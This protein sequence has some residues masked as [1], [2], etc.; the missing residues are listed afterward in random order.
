MRKPYKE[1]AARSNLLVLMSKPT[2]NKVTCLERNCN[3]CGWSSL[4][5]TYFTKLPIS[6]LLIGVIAIVI[7][8]SHIIHAIGGVDF[9]LGSKFP[10]KLL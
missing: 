5:V 6:C 9:T 10:A 8:C 1:N 2:F 7:T 4:G 3:F